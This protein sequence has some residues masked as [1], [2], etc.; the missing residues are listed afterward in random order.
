MKIY[1]GVRIYKLGENM[2]YEN[3][4]IKHLP[5]AFVWKN[6]YNASEG[7]KLDNYIKSIQ[8]EITSEEYLGNGTDGSGF[9]MYVG[10]EEEAE[11]F[12]VPESE[13][14]HIIGM[15][16]QIDFTNPDTD[17]YSVTAKRICS[18][19]KGILH[20]YVVG[21]RECYN[22]KTYKYMYCAG[23]IENYISAR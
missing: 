4:Q 22:E 9:S 12:I 18:D 1:D 14:R 11:D 10:D 16:Y 15:Y 21:E 2:E 13:R 17:G 3:L 23:N 7:R 20:L 8:D 19:G 6:L 5:Y